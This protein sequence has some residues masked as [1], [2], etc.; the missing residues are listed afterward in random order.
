MLPEG[1]DY[2]AVACLIVMDFAVDLIV[3]LIRVGESTSWNTRFVLLFLRGQE[4]SRAERIGLYGELYLV[5]KVLAEFLLVDKDLSDTDDL[6]FFGK[7]TALE[8]EIYASADL[9]SKSKRQRSSSESI[10]FTVFASWNRRQTMKN[11]SLLASW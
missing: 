5:D 4:L 1:A 3:N 10:I 6:T 2:R 7:V 8:K 11:S 9:Q